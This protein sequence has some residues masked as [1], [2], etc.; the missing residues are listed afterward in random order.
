MK[1][2]PP[3]SLLIDYCEKLCV[4][5]CCGIDAYDF[6]PIHIASHLIRARRYADSKE[7]D[8][9]LAQLRAFRQEHGSTNFANA[10][11]SI[12]RMNHSFSAEEV[13]VFVDEIVANIAVAVQLNELSEERRY[14]EY[15]PTEK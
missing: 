12:E 7:V 14:I 13:D 4:A 8:I 9:V 6:S 10:G 5:D 11:I 1:F 3:L 15:R 2:E